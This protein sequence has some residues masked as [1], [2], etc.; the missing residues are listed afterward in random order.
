MFASTVVNV[1]KLAVQQ[2]GL[3]DGADF[4]LV[5]D[6]FRATAGD[7]FLLKAV[8]KLQPFVFNLEGF[9]VGF[10]RVQRLNE[11]GFTKQKFE[12]FDA[13][14]LIAEG[15]LGINGEVGRDD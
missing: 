12:G 4:N 8:G 3:A 9:F 11:F 6:P 14:K 1:I 2:V 5:G 7:F 13:V 15:F 10:L